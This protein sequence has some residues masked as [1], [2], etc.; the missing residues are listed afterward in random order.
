MTDLRWGLIGCG[1][2]A[3]KR[4]APALR[5]APGSTLAAVNRKQTEL[6]QAFADEFGA[7]RVHADWRDLVADPEIDAVYVATPLEPHAEQTIAAAEAGKHVLC[8]KPMAMDVESCDRMIAAAKANGVGLGVAYYRRFYPVLIRMAEL[9]RSGK[10]GIPLQ[11]SV[12]SFERFDT[13]DGEPTPWRLLQ[14]EAG[15]GP[16]MDFGSHRLE[17][18]MSLLGDVD[19]V[20][21]WSDK[22]LF[23]EREVED[24]AGATLKFKSGARASLLISHAAMEP[25]DV[26]DVYLSEGSLHVAQLNTGELRIVTGDRSSVESLPPHANLHQ[27]LVEDFVNAIHEGRR[28]SVTGEDGREVQRLLTEVYAG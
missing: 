2:I 19:T 5:D 15:G 28:P 26:V 18:L 25:R 4:A 13:V 17:L 16:M 22:L 11:A 3:K 10:L 14:S 27:P 20:T 24:S 12:Q 7:S 23:P 21:G 9:I 1:D 8:E 6:A